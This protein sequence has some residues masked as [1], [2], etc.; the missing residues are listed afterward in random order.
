MIE[1]IQGTLEW[2]QLRLG[3]VTASRVA[4]ILA[5]TKTGVSA[6]RGNYLVELAIQ[7]VTGQIE[8]SYTNAAMAWGTETE[9]KA[10][11]AYEV[12]NDILVEQVP[13]VD[14]STIKGFGA[15][16]D[17][18][19]NVDGLCEIK[20]PNSATHWSYLKSGEPPNKYFIQMQAQLSCT[21]RDWNDFISFDPRMPEKSKL[22][23]KRVFRD[24]KFIGIMED[25]VKKFLEEVEEE[26]ELMKGR[27]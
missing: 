23:V 20:C 19:V 3:K 6:S 25:E 26:T 27:E 21:D 17:G 24:D 4:D 8:E 16:P 12:F 14:H 7:R 13:F 9:P 18:L 15:S 22:F 1:I 5:K 10:R 2:H 11:M